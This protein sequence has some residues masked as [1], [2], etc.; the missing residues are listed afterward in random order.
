MELDKVKIF[1]HD[2]NTLIQNSRR[3]SCS[4]DQIY[5]FLEQGFQKFPIT[6]HNLG[7]VYI[8]CSINKLQKPKP[9]AP[10]GCAGWAKEE[11]LFRGGFENAWSRIVDVLSLAYRLNKYQ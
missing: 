6:S 2:L 8:Y 1:D 3:I 10:W 5:C 4:G 11:S 9:V 7:H